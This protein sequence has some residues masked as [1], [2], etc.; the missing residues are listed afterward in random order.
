MA[1]MVSNNQPS[2]SDKAEKMSFSSKD[3]SEPIGSVSSQL[4]LKSSSHNLDKDVVLRR[5]RHHKTMSKVRNAFQSML[6]ADTEE[7]CVEKWL[8]QGDTFTSP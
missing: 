1:F 5:L 6:A 8:Q 4:F 7:L 2:F 3:E